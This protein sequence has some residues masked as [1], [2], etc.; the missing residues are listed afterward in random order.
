M[1]IPFWW[2]ACLLFI[3]VILSE[4]WLPG[5]TPEYWFAYISIHVAYLIGY[6]HSWSRTEDSETDDKKGSYR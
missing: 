5:L 1:R 2:V 6:W 3:W 4:H